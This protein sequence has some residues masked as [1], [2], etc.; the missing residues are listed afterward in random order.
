L[1]R[2]GDEDGNEAT[3]EGSL[4]FLWYRDG[5]AVF[6]GRRPALGN[7]VFEV[8]D[9]RQAHGVVLFL[10]EDVQQAVGEA[11][12]F[13]GML[14]V[15]FSLLSD[16]GVRVKSRLN[17]IPQAGNVHGCEYVTGSAASVGDGL[18]KAKGGGCG[19]KWQWGIGRDYCC[20]CT[21]K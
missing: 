5:L 11:W 8:D 12:L 4:F 16:G 1:G 14:E 21:R 6:F 10:L 3:A 13:F 19:E 17:P 18:E 2:G 20:L 7:A 15:E 9:G